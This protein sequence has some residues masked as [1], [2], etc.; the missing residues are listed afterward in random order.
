MRTSEH[1]FVSIKRDTAPPSAHAAAVASRKRAAGRTARRLKKTITDRPDRR[2]RHMSYRPLSIPSPP[3]RRHY[4]PSFHEMSASA[5]LR[6]ATQKSSEHHCMPAAPPAD[7]GDACFGRYA[8]FAADKQS[9][10][11]RLIFMPPPSSRRRRGHR[12]RA[13]ACRDRLDVWAHGDFHYCT[14]MSV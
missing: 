8:D 12:G 7:I 6:D 3:S 10:A 1:A 2:A 14:V 9:R 11:E 5:R 13:F 4:L